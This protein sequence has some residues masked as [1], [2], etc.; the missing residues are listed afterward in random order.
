MERFEYLPGYS[1]T[2]RAYV[3]DG[4]VVPGFSEGALVS[5]DITWFERKSV[6]AGID[7][8]WFDSRLSGGFDY[9][10]YETTNFLGSPSGASYSDPL[11]TALPKINTNGKHRRA[12]W[13][14]E[15]R[16]KN[17][18][19]ELYYEIGGNMTRFDELWVV[20]HD[21]PEDQL[22]NPNTRETHQK[23]IGEN[24]FI[25][26]G[27]Y[28]SAEDIMNSPKRNNSYDLV[29]GDLKYEDVNGDGQIDSEDNVR[30]GKPSFPR[31]MYGLTVD[32]SYKA[33][34]VG[35]HFQGTGSRHVYLENI[36]QNTNAS[37]IKYPFQTDY[38]TP[39]NTNSRYP[40]LISNDNLNGGNNTVT[41]D[42][43]LVNARYFRMK[44]LQVSYDMKRDLLKKMPFSRFDLFLS[45]TNLFTISKLF[46][47]Y[48][49]DPETDNTN[50]YGYPLQ[51]VFSLGVSVGF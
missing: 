28:Q 24:A 48:K 14:F 46:S 19:N 39:D 3:V 51:K 7:F 34:S 49:M 15:A 31:I 23:G 9:F 37:S 5:R 21:E 26:E 42:F 13:E 45:G 29:P 35:M 25:S 6:N 44:S 4:K 22:K 40:R 20:K 41:S 8:A 18:V 32:L 12:G 11:G 43:W 27:Y 47:N 17:N 1:L 50:N 33:W 2:E 16:Y 38:W 10:F 36:L 30:S